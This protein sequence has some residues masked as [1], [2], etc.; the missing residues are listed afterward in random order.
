MTDAGRI[1]LSLGMLALSLGAGVARADDQQA[2][3][4]RGEYLA[5]AGDC[6]ACHT[7]EGRPAFSGGHA[8][9][10]PLGV[11]YSTNITPS[12][13]AGIGSY[14]LEQFDQALRHG[15]RA[16]GR[17][18][19]PAMP[20]TAYARMRDEDIAALYAYFMHG[21]APVDD[22]PEKTDLPFPFNLRFSMAAWNGLF[23]D[24]TP[25]TPDPDKSEQFNR[26]AYLVEGLTH[27]S[28]CH[29]PRNMLMAEKQDQALK[30]ASLGTWYAPDITANPNTGI[31]QWSQQ[32]LIE[33]LTTG[34]AD[35]GA[36]AGGPMLEAID[37]SFSRMTPEDIKAIATYLLPDSPDTSAPTP[38]PGLRPIRD[39]DT[40]AALEKIGP[41]ERVYRDSCATCHGM[42]GEGLNGLP[43]LKGHP[44]LKKPTADNVSM[45]ILEGVWPHQGQAMIG[46]DEELSDTEIAEVTN[47][48][49]HAFGRSDVHTD[50][51][52][53]A[54]LR[55]GGATSPLLML[56]RV[57]MV[58]A[59][60]ALV[61]LIAWS[62]W[63]RRRG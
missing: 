27:C 55:Q 20:Y 51:A 32:Q 2:L 47:Y 22:A 5:I 44:V 63:R 26:G 49:M 52:R 31:G 56:A 25:F 10:S 6:A 62:I 34:H 4:Q 61:I 33:Y 12:D 9:S 39:N 42:Q 59:G 7:E 30:G 11:I 41:G 3:I 17:Q 53:V 57:G 37:K 29:T 45:A 23:L 24:Q 60:V 35:N 38:A 1:V 48:V 58:G 43:A 21:V 14:S 18:L 28:T 15:V 50:A 40:P 8:I 19:Y 36:T 46:F 54:E 16:D 13:S